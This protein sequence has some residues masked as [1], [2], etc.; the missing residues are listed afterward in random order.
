MTLLLKS[1]TENNWEEIFEQPKIISAWMDFMG[2]VLIVF[3][4]WLWTGNQL[5]RVTSR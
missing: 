1:A 2:K 3:H 4:N 5:V